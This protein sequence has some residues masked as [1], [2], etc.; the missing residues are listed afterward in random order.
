MQ[1]WELDT[2]HI[3]SKEKRKEKSGN[4]RVKGFTMEKREERGQD[5]LFCPLPLVFPLWWTS[6]YEREITHLC[7]CRPPPQI[8]PGK[9]AWRR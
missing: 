4:K 3:V 1:K 5:N 8:P 9:I 6:I 7:L 2:I